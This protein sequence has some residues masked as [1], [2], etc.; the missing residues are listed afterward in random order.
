MRGDEHS[1]LRWFNVEEACSLDDLA[2]D[3]YRASFRSLV[4]DWPVTNPNGSN[5]ALRLRSEIPATSTVGPLCPE[6]RPSNTEVRFLA[7]YVRF[8]PSRRL[9][10]GGERKFGPAAPQ[11]QTAA[12]RSRRYFLPIK[13]VAPF[14]PVCSE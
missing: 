8:T 14:A 1:E 4:Q 3:E 9:L 7:K 6:S 13:M 5:V 12:I 10:L 11:A 2:L